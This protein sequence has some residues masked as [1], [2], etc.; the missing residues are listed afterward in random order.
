MKNN[1]LDIFNVMDGWLEPRAYLKLSHLITMKK[2]D[3]T[4]IGRICEPEWMG[5]ILHPHLS[6]FW[7]RYVHLTFFLYGLSAVDA[8]FTA[9]GWGIRRV[10]RYQKKC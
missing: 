2:I 5:R 4:T 7:A 1:S 6:L 9:R 3:K 10:R 8:P